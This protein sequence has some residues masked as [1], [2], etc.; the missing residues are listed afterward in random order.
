MLNCGDIDDIDDISDI[1]DIDDIDDTND[2]DDIAD[3]DDTNDIDDIVDEDEDYLPPI[4]H[5]PKS[6]HNWN[7]SVMIISSAANSHQT[8]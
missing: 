6:H 7:L 4:S 3:I 1:G 2:I 8:D 5:R